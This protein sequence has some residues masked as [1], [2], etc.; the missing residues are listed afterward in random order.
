MKIST[1][2]AMIL[3]VPGERRRARGG[4]TSPRARA[5]ALDGGYDINRSRAAYPDGAQTTLVRITTDDGLV[6]WGEAHA[7]LAPEVT[8]SIIDHLLGPLLIGSDPRAV[9]VLWERMY[10]SMRIR[11]HRTGF[12]MEAMSGIDIALWDLCGKAQ[13]LPVY[14]LLGGAHRDR[15]PI[16]ASGVPGA[17]AEEQVENALGFLEQGFTAMKLGTGGLG[18]VEGLKRVRAVREAVGDRAHVLVDAQG[19]YDLHTAL[20]FGRELEQLDVYW[21]EDPLPPEDID[22]HRRLAASLDVA[23]A[24]GEAFCARWGFRDWLASGALDVALPDICRVGGISE[25]RKV[26][27]LA[28]AYNIPWAAHVSMGTAVH[29]AASVHLG[30]ATPNLLICEYPSR[31]DHNPLGYNLLQ[32]P[33]QVEGAALRVPQGPGLGIAF[34]EE[35]LARFIVH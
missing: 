4:D 8:K 12:M 27:M 14:L 34:D 33:L 23:V 13:G 24:T 30:A 10:T 18:P 19:G 7:P 32:E 16:Y 28:D 1:V 31:F 26:A 15:V 9:E 17:S 11:G 29:V 22:G 20:I 25:C 2:E 21:V 6:G 3:R 5:R 35:A